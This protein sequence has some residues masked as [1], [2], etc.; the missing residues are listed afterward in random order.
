MKNVICTLNFVWEEGSFPKGQLSIMKWAG[1]QNR[2]K[3]LQGGSLG[4]P[5]KGR[6][7]VEEIISRC[8]QGLGTEAWT[9]RNGKKSR[10]HYLLSGLIIILVS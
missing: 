1:P 8:V 9:R 3:G 5:G 6:K 10:F 4:D 7:G 2:S